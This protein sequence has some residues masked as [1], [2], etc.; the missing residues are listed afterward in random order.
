MF[1]DDYKA[2]FSK[3]TASG[4][5]HRRILNMTKEH[6][7]RRSFGGWASKLLI[8]AVLVSLLVVSASAAE[9]VRGW[10]SAY[11]SGNGQTPLSEGQEKYIQ[12]NEQ[13]IAESQTQNG[14]TVE[15][16]S[17]ISDGMKGYIMLGVTAP[18]DVNL[19]EIPGKST[20]EY[21]G[22]GNDYLPKDPDA[23]LTCSAYPD[24]SV[25]ANIGANWLEDGDGMANTVNYVIDVSP[26]AEFAD[27]DP[28]SSE[29]LWHIH[30]V[31]FVHGFPEQEP[32]T[33]GVWDFDFTFENDKTEIELLTKPMKT[34]ALALPG[35]GTE[36]DAEVTMTSVVLRP[37]GIT[38]SYGDASDGLDYARTSVSFGELTTG[39]SPWFAV[40]K[41]GSRMQL[42]YG[43]GNPVVRNCLL[44][45]QAP[46]VLENVDYILLSDGTRLPMPELPTK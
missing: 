34:E 24:T 35:D 18:K 19:E 36:M 29:A 39:R 15:L 32:L 21:Y 42:C 2:A 12:E 44:E 8:A 27:F 40:M 38:V 46:I 33:K 20:Q 9:Y 4:E 26:D 25:V 31:D 10:F 43:G 13:S 23:V 22:P 28:F 37:F 14:W 11:F 1:K 30:I 3:V 41:D 17:A 5:T 45:A 16:R 7:K 6:K